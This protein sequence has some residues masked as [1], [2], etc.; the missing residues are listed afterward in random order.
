MEGV[1]GFQGSRSSAP[2]DLQRLE[3][4]DS[5]SNRH[6]ALRYWW[7]MIPASAGTG[8]FRKPVSTF[9]DHALPSGL[10]GAFEIAF[11]DEAPEIRRPA[12][13]PVFPAQLED[14]LGANEVELA[15]GI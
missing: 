4:D 3:R 6:P 1:C 5:S 7:S 9:R 14:L 10:G 11:V 15:A 2:A 13:R 12:R 8:L